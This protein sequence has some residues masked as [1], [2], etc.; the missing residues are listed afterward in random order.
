M[1]FLKDKENFG[2]GYQKGE[3]LESF[4]EKLISFIERRV[5]DKISSKVNYLLKRVNDGKVEII[6]D[7][8]EDK[9][10]DGNWRE[11]ISGDDLLKQR[12]NGTTDTWITVWTYKG[13]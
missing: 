11:T 13:S 8:N 3:G 5:F 10:Q 9:N 1:E 2:T 7:G 6:K 4:F 12:Y